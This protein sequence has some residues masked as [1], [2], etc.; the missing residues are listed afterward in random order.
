[1]K[2]FVRLASIGS[3]LVFAAMVSVAGAAYQHAG[4]A[5][6]DATIFLNVYPDAAGTKLDNC[7]L[8]HGGGKY[9]DPKTQKTTAMGSCQYC[10]AVTNYGTQADQY[11]TTL[12]PFGAAYQANGRD[13]TALKL[14]ESLD[15]DG[16]GY[17]SLAEI[18]AIRYPGASNDDPT[19]VTAPFKV[20]DKARL[21][22]M[23][24]HTQF[25][26]MNTTKSGDYYVEYSGVR[27]DYL[28]KAAGIRSEATEITVYAPDGYSVRHPIADSPS[29]TGTSYAPYVKGEYPQAVYY[30]DSVADTATGGW[31]DYTSPGNLGRVNGEAIDVDGGLRMI[32][33]LR[34]DGMDLAPGYLD[35]T[36]KLASG[37]EGP[38]RTVT[39]QKTVGSPDQPSNK[40]NPTLIW[41]YDSAA[42]HNA[43]FSSKSAT[44]IKVGPLPEGTTDIDVFEAG[45]SYVDSG[46]IVVYGDI[47]P[48]AEHSGQALGSCLHHSGG[49]LQSL[50]ESPIQMCAAPR[51]AGGALP[52]LKEMLQMVSQCTRKGG[53]AG[54]PGLQ[55][56]EEALQQLLGNRLR[57]PT[58]PPLV[59]PGDH[60]PSENSGLTETPP[61]LPH[62]K[63]CGR[64]RPSRHPAR[65]CNGRTP[66]VM[67]KSAGTRYG[68]IV[69]LDSRFWQ[70]TCNFRVARQLQEGSR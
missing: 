65:Q 25:M 16:D 11:G 59:G 9:T 35:A 52:R 48:Q 56:D 49:R 15:S 6:K 7:A 39:P 5:E 31:C 27:M 61:H 57:S 17:S 1:M 68:A 24:Q 64:C 36:N 46:K 51:S 54:S 20:F 4:D 55:P 45:W 38:F 60:H 8:C 3:L 26:L 10:H 43:G 33:A 13:E 14:I 42:D 37:T 50:Q 29:N 12:N 67:W 53:V 47:D 18:T 63:A 23:P 62:V 66:G 28:L 32:L 22:A 19:K 44:I 58:K 40:S 34:A 21:E 2:Q 70:A 41:P 30:Y 69:C